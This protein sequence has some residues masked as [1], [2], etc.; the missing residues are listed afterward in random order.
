MPATP[1]LAE[2]VCIAILSNG[3]GGV[4]VGAV[5]R[6]W[7]V[8]IYLFHVR[9]TLGNRKNAPHSDLS[10]RD[11]TVKLAIGCHLIKEK[12]TLSA[13]IIVNSVFGAPTQTDEFWQYASLQSAVLKALEECEP[14]RGYP[15]ELPLSVRARD[16]EAGL[17]VPAGP[18]HDV[19][20]TTT[21]RHLHTLC[22]EVFLN[23]ENERLRLEHDP[24]SV[25]VGSDKARRLMATLVQ[26]LGRISG[27]SE[28]EVREYVNRAGRGEDWGSKSLP[29]G[30][31]LRNISEVAIHLADREEKLLPDLLAFI[32]REHP[33][34]S[35]E[36]GLGRVAKADGGHKK[37]ADDT[38]QTRIPKRTAPRLG[39]SKTTLGR[40]QTRRRKKRTMADLTEREMQAYKH[41][42]E[43]KSYTAVGREMGISRQSAT[44]MVKRATCI[45]NQDVRVPRRFEVTQPQ[46]TRS[47]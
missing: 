7:P 33:H 27:R 8:L 29:N 9:R 34:E 14:M 4:T 38:S 17:P 36:I 32:E 21:P 22:A 42:A 18:P 24:D 44:T 5:E 15:P 11:E 30:E 37:S 6:C 25:S 3:G 19:T 20:L 12:D 26:E 10:F 46:P 41:Y 31:S 16:R 2:K 47:A 23:D 40:K 45:I 39:A 43:L 35:A 13:S 28:A 1:T